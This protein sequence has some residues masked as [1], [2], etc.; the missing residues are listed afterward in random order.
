M[1]LNQIKTA[2][3]SEFHNQGGNQSELS[4]RTGL[5]RKAVYAFLYTDNTPYVSTIIK[6]C[7]GLGLELVVRKKGGAE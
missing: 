1:N 3:S 6:I 4:R 5:D 2:I 7:D